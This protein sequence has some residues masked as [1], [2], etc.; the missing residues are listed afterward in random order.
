MIYS[1]YTFQECYIAVSPLQAS[2]LPSHGN[3][4]ASVLGKLP[5]TEQASSHDGAEE[6]DLGRAIARARIDN[7]ATARAV[8]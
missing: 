8:S 6:H 3:G 4:E 1:C 7:A 5:Y 2:F